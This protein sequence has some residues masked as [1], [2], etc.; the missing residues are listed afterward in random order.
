MTYVACRLTAKNQDQLRNSTLCNRVLAT[1]TF[2]IVNRA[3]TRAQTHIHTRAL[4]DALNDAAACCGLRPVRD[5]RGISAA[6]RAEVCVTAV[7]RRR[8]LLLFLC[9]RDADTAPFV[10]VS[11][12]PS[13]DVCPPPAR[14]VSRTASCL[15]T[16]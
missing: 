3:H 14:P 9:E 10:V 4:S 2:F 11:F 16:N 12:R 1:F 7:N 13:L 6:M 5:A 8:S 15:P